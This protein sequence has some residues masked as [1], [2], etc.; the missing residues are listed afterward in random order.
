MFN[1]TGNKG[2]HMTFANGFKASV[3]WGS[4]NYCDNYNSTETF[5][6]NVPPSSTA[7]VAAFTP[8]DDFIP[9]RNGDDVMGH[10]KT[11]E[12]LAFL[13]AVAGLSMDNLAENCELLLDTSYNDAMVTTAS[14]EIRNG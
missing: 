10:L 3:Q 4:G 7:E 6:R 1:S 11:D 9:L 8:S 2:F 13:N 5:G 14:K 12:V